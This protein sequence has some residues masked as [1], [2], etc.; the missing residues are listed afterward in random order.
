MSMWM[1][2]CYFEP[3]RMGPSN[4][5]VYFAELWQKELRETDVMWHEAS[6]TFYGGET[7]IVWVV[8]ALIQLYL[9][10]CAIRGDFD[11][12]EDPPE[13]YD[14]T[15][16]NVHDYDRIAK[17]IDDWILAIERS[18]E[19][20]RETSEERKQGLATNSLVLDDGAANA[21]LILDGPSTSATPI[22][23]SPVSSTIFP[24]VRA[25]ARS[26]KHK[27]RVRI[28]PSDGEETD[29]SQELNYDA[30][31]QTAQD[32]SDWSKEDTSQISRPADDVFPPDDPIG[33]RARYGFDPKVPHQ[34]IDGT[35]PEEILP[36]MPTNSL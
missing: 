3:P 25:P 20:L 4:G 36:G 12:P 17:W 8:R 24:D 34:V 1:P 16:F 10:C 21:E 6:K 14:L 26:A 27:K 30:L 19:I 29:D 33:L 35:G 2:K 18:I 23:T 22:P 9:N 7:G 32:D 11:P 31:D 13:D 28:A 5:Q 15:R